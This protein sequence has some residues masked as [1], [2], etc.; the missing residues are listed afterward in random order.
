[1]VES[2]ARISGLRIEG[3]SGEAS[4]TNST[5]GIQLLPG[6]Q[7]VEIDNNELYHWPHDPGELRGRAAARASLSA[8]QLVSASRSVCTTGRC[9]T[10][11]NAHQPASWAS[12]AP[13]I[14]V[15]ISTQGLNCHSNSK[16]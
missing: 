7:G 13:P 12:T 5:I 9:S 2:G 15:P 1:M 14:V 11:R 16:A 8:D 4:S 3:P 6:T 10:P